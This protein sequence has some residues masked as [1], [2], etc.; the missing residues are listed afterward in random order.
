MNEYEGFFSPRY[1][2]RMYGGSISEA[3][4]RA[5]CRRSEHPIP[6]IKSGCKRPF[7]KIRP[8]VFEAWLN[9]EM[10]VDETVGAVDR[11]AGRRVDG[12][13]S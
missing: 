5:A 13:R 1:I 12:A 4:I 7:V 8:S 2:S 6:H 10:R 3:E 9:E 11:T